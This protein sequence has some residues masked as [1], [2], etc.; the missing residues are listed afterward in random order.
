MTPPVYSLQSVGKLFGYR[1][2]LEDVTLDIEP[3]DFTLL[4]GNNGAGKTTLLRILSTLM[5]ASSGRIS[6]RGQP[7][8]AAAP[9]AR[10]DL[11]MISHE[12][13]SYPD[14]TALENLRVT[15]ALYGVAD[16][17]RRSREALAAAGLDNVPDIPARAFSSGMLKRLAIARLMLYRPRVLLLD[18]P[19]SGLDQGSLAL[20][21][22]FLTAFR[23]GGGTTVMV[24]HQFTGGVGL[25]SR[26]AVLQQGGLVYNQS[27][28]DVT[29]AS[30]AELLQRFGGA[31]PRPRAGG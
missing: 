8:P 25:A 12:S 2:A 21:D 29:P 11:G 19:Y 23:D 7:F 4:L 15:G 27:A 24:T 26:I 1:A 16:T 18:E 30:C 17:A 13:R 9:S 3:G 6:F 28:R 22:E 31:A 14:L 5:R 10:R 20:L